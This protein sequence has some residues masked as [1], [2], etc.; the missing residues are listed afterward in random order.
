[1]LD[2]SC[3]PVALACYYCNTVAGDFERDDIVHCLRCDARIDDDARRCPECGEPTGLG[4]GSEREAAVEELKARRRKAVVVGFGVLLF[5]AVVGHGSWHLIPGIHISHGHHHESAL[6]VDAVALYDA[7][8]RDSD[9]ADDKYGGR[10]LQ[11]TGTFLQI[12]KDDDGNP[13]LQLKT[14]DPSNP[15]GVDVASDSYSAAVGLQPGQRVTLD[16]DRVAEGHDEHWLQNCHIEKGPP[17]PEP[18]ATA[19]VAP[20]AAQAPAPSGAPAPPAR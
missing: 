16:C 18:V 1:M 17:P 15:L 12:R 6:T 19:P 14:S 3:A 13:D 5:V 8:R 11:V 10:E 2:G 9:A 4:W 7:Y 20:P